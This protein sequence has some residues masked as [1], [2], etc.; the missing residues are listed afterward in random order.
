VKGLEKAASEEFSHILLGFPAARCNNNA[1][2]VKIAHI[3]ECADKKPFYFEH[4][5]ITSGCTME[6]ELPHFLHRLW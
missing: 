6:R 3:F 2:H 4:E 5:D 1:D